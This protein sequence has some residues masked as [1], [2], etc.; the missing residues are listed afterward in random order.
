MVEI[1]ILYLPY[2]NPFDKYLLFNIL[3]HYESSY[4]FL[5]S[6]PNLSTPKEISAVENESAIKT[7]KNACVYLQS[8]F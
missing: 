5:S 6:S 8:R 2:K 4:Y 7:D 1:D 3:T